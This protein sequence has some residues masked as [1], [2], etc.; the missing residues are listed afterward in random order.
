MKTFNDLMVYTISITQPNHH[1]D[2]RRLILHTTHAIFLL[3]YDNGYQKLHT[4]VWV[5]PSTILIWHP[6]ISSTK[7]H[8]WTQWDQGMPNEKIKTKWKCQVRTPHN[9]IFYSS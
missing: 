1:N 7:Y 2:T 8:S 5:I 3:N 6:W 4:I 9:R